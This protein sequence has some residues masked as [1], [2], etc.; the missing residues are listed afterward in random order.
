MG[1]L[2][3]LAAAVAVSL[4]VIAPAAAAA[5]K[6]PV[7][8]EISRVSGF[9]HMTFQ[10]GV[11]ASCPANPLCGYSGDVRFDIAESRRGGT[12]VLAPGN[13]ENFGTAA[14]RGT[15]TASVTNPAIPGACTESVDHFGE[16]VLLE[17]HGSRVAVVMHPSL[18]VGPDVLR[19]RC[20]GPGESDLTLANAN[21]LAVVPLSRFK[22]RSV[23]LAVDYQAPFTA[24]PFKGQVEMHMRLLLKRSK[25]LDREI[26]KHL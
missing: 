12:I 18:D 17:V 13:G 10:G 20:A 25:R 7:G 19:T 4:V 9:E 14:T 5:K 16:N 26:S 11:G 23:S 15:T 3:R 24:E 21:P 6:R 22:K 1:G 8:F 2:T